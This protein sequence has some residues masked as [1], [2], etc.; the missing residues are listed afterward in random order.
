MRQRGGLG[1]RS[2]RRQG[3]ISPGRSPFL[4]SSRNGA[5]SSRNGHHPRKRGSHVWLAVLVTGVLCLG[6]LLGLMAGGTAGPERA[7]QTRQPARGTRATALA[8]PPRPAYGWVPAA[9]AERVAVKLKRPLRSGLLFD[10]HTGRVL[11]ARNQDRVLPI[12]SLT[13]M[14]TAL[15][16][17][18]HSR[19]SDHVLITP[20]AVHF[21][22]SGVGL[23]PLGKRVPLMAL[24]YGLLLPSGND[25]AI[26]LAQHV[27]GTQSR[28]VAMMNERA[29]AMGL[30]CTHFSSPSGILDR[31][32]HS[33]VGDLAILAHQMLEQPPLARIVSSRT[34]VVRFPI[35]GGKLYLY[36]NNPL[37][38]LGYPG[39]DGVKT[40]YTNAAGHCLVATVRRGGRWLGVVLLHSYETGLQAPTILNAAFGQAHG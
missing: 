25:A 29:Q 26:A 24:L 3:T 1:R 22:G 2:S 10:V 30:Q 23:L 40:G 36:N 20:Q 33:C 38:V 31:G 15:L 35:K 6:V 11:W 39:T 5:Y 4:T 34:A 8:P 28:F 13:K 12:A 18:A 14:M 9:P 37:L 19:P 17:M 21:S 27:A 7:A 16:V 32:N